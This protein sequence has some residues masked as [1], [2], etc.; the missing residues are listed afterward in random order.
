LTKKLGYYSYQQ[1]FEILKQRASITFLN[2]IDKEI[3]EIITDLIFEHYVPVPGKGIEVLKEIYPVL[4]EKNKYNHLEILKIIQNQFDAIQLSDEFNLL[5][6][7]SDEELLTILFLDNISSYFLKNSH[8]YITSKKL[9]ELYY[10]SCET[11]EYDKILEHFYEIVK[12]F[13]NIGIFSLSKRN[14]SGKLFFL[15]INPK[16]LKTIVDTIFKNF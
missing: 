15:V 13:Q 9:K 7:I 11:I 12:K 10:I 2:Q 8:Y 6:Y 16:R 5:T 14:F 3:I 4:N 1:L